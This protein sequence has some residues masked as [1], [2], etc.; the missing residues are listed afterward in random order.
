MLQIVKE[1]H[2]ITPKKRE[3]FILRTTMPTLKRA[4]ASKQVL[5]TVRQVQKVRNS[6]WDTK[7]IAAFSLEIADNLHG[8]HLRYAPLCDLSSM[9]PMS[10][11][12]VL[13]YH[14]SDP[15]QCLHGIC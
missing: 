4:I 7:T 13:T 10:S 5:M 9:R 14:K 11:C 1:S 15:Y 8:Q 12:S 3:T 2:F 6:N